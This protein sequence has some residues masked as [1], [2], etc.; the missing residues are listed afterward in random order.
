MTPLALATLAL[1]AAAGLAAVVGRSRPVAAY[2]GAVL[3]ID[4]VRWAQALLLPSPPELR[5]GWWLAA[6]WAEVGLYI[7][8]ILVLPA[9]AVALFRHRQ[10]SNKNSRLEFGAVE[11]ITAAWLLLTTW[12]AGS[13]PDLRGPALLRIYDLVELGAV[14]ASLACAGMWF[15]R[16]LSFSARVSTEEHDARRI[17]PPLPGLPGGP[18]R[19]AT[20]GRRAYPGGSSPGSG[21][22]A[23]PRCVPSLGPA[24]AESPSPAH[25]AGLALIAGPAGSCVLPWLTTDTVLDGWPC[26]VAGNAVAVATCLVLLLWGLTGARRPSCTS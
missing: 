14:A 9:M 6:W 8:S 24:A 25:L 11:L 10:E 12:I 16:L 18:Y 1:Y 13:Y 22:A 21:L 5:A 23:L 19:R 20:V 2:L 7:G 3:A 17:P 26:I 15:Q 4:A